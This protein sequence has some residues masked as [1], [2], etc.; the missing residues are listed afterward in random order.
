MCKLISINE[1]LMTRNIELKNLDTN[2]I[3]VCFDDSALLSEINF[4]FMKINNNYK[5]KI[6]LFGELTHNN[7]SDVVKCEIKNKDILIGKKIFT[8]VD[9]ENN[10][11]YIYQEQIKNSLHKESFLF[12][13]SRKDIIQ[14]DN[15][16]S[17]DLL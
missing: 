11:Y 9:V 2:I 10:I 4:E 12:D 3:D 6:K 8:K 7:G 1:D 16:I 15:I 17:H 5:C 13:V 14:V